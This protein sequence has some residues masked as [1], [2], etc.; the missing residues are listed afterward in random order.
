MT[1]FSSRGR[2]ISFPNICRSWNWLSCLCSLESQP[3]QVSMFFS[4]QRINLPRAFSAGVM[5]WEVIELIPVRMISLGILSS[6]KSRSDY[7][8]AMARR[9][10]MSRSGA[11]S[12]SQ[13]SLK[14][15]SSVSLKGDS[16][17]VSGSTL[18]CVQL[19]VTVIRLLEL[20]STWTQFRSFF[21][22]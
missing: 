22:N 3:F 21:G 20:K 14:S 11:S 7:N 17:V 10:K 13:I 6:E 5:A 9:E 4:L 8:T 1:K 19:S 16:L 12:S 18:D 15:K 2:V